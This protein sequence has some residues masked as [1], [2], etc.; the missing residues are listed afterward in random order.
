M[1]S[2]LA[3]PLMRACARPIAIHQAVTRKLF[4]HLTGA[5]RVVPRQ[6]H[7]AHIA[8]A[9]EETVAEA[10][11]TDD[12][13]IDPLPTGYLDFRVGRILS[14]ERHPDA[15]SLYVEKIDLNE[16]EPRTIVSGL[17]EYVPLEEMQDRL[18]VV[19]ANLKARNMRGI[20]SHGMVLCASDEGHKRVEP[21]VPPEGA[22]VS[23]PQIAL[24][25]V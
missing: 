18:V 10:A 22:Q 6:L 16:E 19:L 12:P 7:V 23:A 21:L 2:V 1:S 11:S 4:P 14:C 15:D 8:R 17:V 25:F 9:A 24:S 20:K 3:Q 5:L 13:E